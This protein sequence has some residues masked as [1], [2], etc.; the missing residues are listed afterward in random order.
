M[1]TGLII[2]IGPR[3]LNSREEMFS[4]I[5]HILARQLVI[6]YMLPYLCPSLS[7][8]APKKPIWLRKI[9]RT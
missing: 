6:R 4:G 5:E 1:F 2:I 7:N 3:D 8:L 9:I